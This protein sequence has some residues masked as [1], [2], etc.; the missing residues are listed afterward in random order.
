[1]SL[2][3]Y[4][5]G[6]HFLFLIYFIEVE[7]IYNTVLVSGVEQSDSVLYVWILF[8]IIFHCRLL[9]NIEYSSLCYTGNSCCLSILCIVVCIC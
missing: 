4:L 5:F 3:Y 9:H 7:L 1:M 2:S 6:I 8:Q